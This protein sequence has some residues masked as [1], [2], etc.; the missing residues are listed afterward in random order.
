VVENRA[1]RAANRFHSGSF[2]QAGR[3]PEKNG[4]VEC[5]FKSSRCGI[6]TS[7]AKIS[8]L[9]T[10]ADWLTWQPDD[11]RFYFEQHCGMLRF[12][13]LLFGSDWPMAT[14]ATTYGRWVETVREL[15]FVCFGNRVEAAVS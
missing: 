13:R 7:S 1:P 10:E 2:W 12:K 15:V 8:G 14:L 6:R 3:A 11:L 9:T 5:G 4:A